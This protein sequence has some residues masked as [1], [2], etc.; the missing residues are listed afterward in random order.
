MAVAGLALIARGHECRNG[1]GLEG[2][3]DELMAV[4]HVLECDENVAGPKRTGVYRK[5][6]DGLVNHA[7]KRGGSSFNQRF[8][9]P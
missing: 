5:T 1:A 3:G 7:V 4:A 8:G 2:G 9:S 6:G